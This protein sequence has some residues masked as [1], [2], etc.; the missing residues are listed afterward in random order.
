MMERHGGDRYEA[1]REQL[2][3]EFQVGEPQMAT[4]CSIELAER[5]NGAH[6]VSF[7]FRIDVHVAVS[8]WGKVNG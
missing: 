2:D 8:V 3:D 1:I 7:V 4:F 5:E 6:P